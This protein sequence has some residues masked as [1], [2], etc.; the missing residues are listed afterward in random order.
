MIDRRGTRARSAAILRRFGIATLRQAFAVADRPLLAN[1]VGKLQRQKGRSQI[2][3]SNARD[4]SILDKFVRS[5]FRKATVAAALGSH[6][7]HFHPGHLIGGP[8]PL[9]TAG[10]GRRSRHRCGTGYPACGQSWR[11]PAFGRASSGSARR[12]SAEPVAVRVPCRQHGSMRQRRSCGTGT[13]V[14]SA[15]SSR[16][17]MEA[18]ER[19]VISRRLRML[20]GRGQRRVSAMGSG[21]DGR[22]HRVPRWTS[23]VNSWPTDFG[24]SG[25]QKSRYIMRSA[26][27]LR[28]LSP[29]DFADEAKEA[30]PASFSGVSNQRLATLGW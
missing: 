7:V 24:P 23:V 5:S 3:D 30:R 20:P 2:A 18:T 28:R 9:H 8:G 1:Y 15:A 22:L 19:W 4:S 11:T 16:R 29:T 12:T 6:E 25:R 21:L 27:Y 26:S 13:F 14:S 17:R 10:R